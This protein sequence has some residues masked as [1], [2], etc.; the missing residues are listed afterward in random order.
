LP[1]DTD[2]G[3]SKF[4]ASTWKKFHGFLYFYIREKVV[5]QGNFKIDGRS[6]ARRWEGF[7]IS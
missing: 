1:G 6:I 4:H 3:Y 5:I 2:L 7:S